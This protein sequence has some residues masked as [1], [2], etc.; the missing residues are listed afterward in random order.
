M[1][2][3][4]QVPPP[5]DHRSAAEAWQFHLGH[6]ALC[7]DFANTVSWRGS[8]AL[9]DHLPSYGELVRFALQATMVSAPEGAPRLRARGEAPAPRGGSGR[10]LRRALALRDPVPPGVLGP[11]RPRRE[12][13]AADL[14]VLN[15]V[16]P[17]AL[18][19][20][21][22]APVGG[23]VPVGL[24]G[25]P[26]ALDRLLWP[27]ARDA[28]VFLTSG[29]PLPPAHLR[30]PA[31]RLDLPRHHEERHAPLRPRW[32]C[33]ETAPRSAASAAAGAPRAPG[34][35]RPALGGRIRGRGRPAPALD[36]HPAVRRVL[37]LGRQVAPAQWLLLHVGLAEQQGKACAFISS[38]PR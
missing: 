18:V 23:V 26:D 7:V 35:R 37:A 25:A 11:G 31:L 16:L 4:G 2:Y 30:E 9:V 12:P 21:R 3:R 19:H 22:V 6:G 8:G 38:R 34:S 29:E 15:T 36:A 27:V 28:A 5:R 20:L 32:P 17:D 14:D 10:A 24:E 13:V 33:A 1:L